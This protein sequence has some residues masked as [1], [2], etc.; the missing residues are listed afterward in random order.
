MPAPAFLSTSTFSVLIFPFDNGIWLADGTILP[1]Y[2]V[3]NQAVYWV[4]GLY[5][6]FDNDFCFSSHVSF[7]FILYI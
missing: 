1:I 5:L 6:I 7:D 4:V 3:P 2:L